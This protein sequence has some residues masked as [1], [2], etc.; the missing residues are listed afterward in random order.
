MANKSKTELNTKGFVESDLCKIIKERIIDTMTNTKR[1]AVYEHLAL[2]HQ[3]LKLIQ[4][5]GKKEQTYLFRFVCDNFGAVEPG[6]RYEP[7]QIA[8]EQIACIDKLDWGVVRKVIERGFLE[9]DLEADELYT[10]LWEFVCNPVPILEL[11]KYT[12]N[13]EEQLVRSVVF[14]LILNSNYI[15]YYY[16]GERLTMSSGEFGEYLEKMDNELRQ[17][18]FVL[19]SNTYEQNSEQA[20]HIMK[21]IDTKSDHKERAVLLALV[22]AHFQNKISKLEKRDKESE[23]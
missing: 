9:R 5:V 13:A 4:S 23:E 6:G 12:A 3:I 18:G 10:K 21:I 17:V 19:K 14:L 16:F 8:A 2:C 22:L 15:P 7:E 20:S 1:E 11:N